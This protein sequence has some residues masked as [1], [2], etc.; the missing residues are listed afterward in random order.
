M[1]ACEASFLESR[2]IRSTREPEHSAHAT[3]PRRSGRHTQPRPRNISSQPSSTATTPTSEHAI[4]AALETADRA[5]ILSAFV[6]TS[7]VELLVDDLRDALT[8]C[9][10]IRFLTGDYLGVTSADALRQLLRLAEEHHGFA[11]YFYETRANVAFH[12]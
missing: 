8:R 7:G 5:D 6:Q 9:V 4:R 2:S 12:P 1:A 3:G 11:P 10:Q